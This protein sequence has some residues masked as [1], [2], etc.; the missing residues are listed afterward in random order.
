MCVLCRDF[1][2][3]ALVEFKKFG[4]GMILKAGFVL[5]LCKPER[6]PVGT[7]PSC[8]IRAHRGACTKL[9]FWQRL[10]VGSEVWR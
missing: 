8:N 7:C 5:W 2:W 9:F 3:F 1:I 6:A 10:V 4:I